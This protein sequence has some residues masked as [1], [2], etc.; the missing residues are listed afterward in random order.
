[1]K[2]VV[3]NALGNLPLKRKSYVSR[4]DACN[5]VFNA[6][7]QERQHYTGKRHV[8][9]MRMMAKEERAGKI[10]ILRKNLNICIIVQTA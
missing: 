1:M 3:N 2:A 8:K 4:C 10:K 6:E 9:R 7:S 5:L